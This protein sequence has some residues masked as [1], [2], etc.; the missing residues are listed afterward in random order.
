MKLFDFLR[1]QRAAL[2][3]ASSPATAATPPVLDVPAVEAALDVPEATHEHHTQLPDGVVTAAAWAWRL[4]LFGVFAVALFKTLS[5]FSAVSVPVAIA[6]LLTALLAPITDGLRK[7]GLNPGLSAALALL[8]MFVVIGGIVVAVALQAAEQAPALVDQS[9]AGIQQLLNWLGHGPF[10]LSPEQL[11]GVIDQLTEWLKRSASTIA[12]SA[13]AV[14]ASIGNFLAGTAIALMAAFFFIYQGRSLFEG[15]VN[16]LLPRNYRATVLAASVKGWTSLVSYMRSVVIIAL[17]DAVGIAL[18]AAI[19]KVPMVA[20]IFALT[21]IASFIPIV[22]A[23][24][25]GA[26]AV[27]LALVTH[28]WVT[29]MIMLGG[30]LGV[31]FV[32]GNVLQPF[33]MGKS[34]ELHPLATLLGLTVGTTISGIL[35]ALL[36]I[37]VMAFTVAFLRAVRD[38]RANAAVPNPTIEAEPGPPLEAEPSESSG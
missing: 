21:F 10:G 9:M 28:D 1:R 27:A 5:Y 12:S 26:V 20:A 30:V 32:E 24:V 35:G 18:V 7:I 33:L 25:A 4:L 22:G 16:W 37:P 11:N 36:V 3:E 8:V 13:A 29:A 2:V 38:V 23:F 15:I 14:G 19:L 34:V 6:I 31:N 17:V